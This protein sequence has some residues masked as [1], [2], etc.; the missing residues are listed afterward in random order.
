MKQIGAIHQETISAAW[1]DHLNPT[2]TLASL[3]ALM[4]LCVP[5]FL[6][7]QTAAAIFRVA[8]DQ[9]KRKVG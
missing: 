1:T 9:E 6:S 2:P 3:D 8:Q 7:G 4:C 5:S